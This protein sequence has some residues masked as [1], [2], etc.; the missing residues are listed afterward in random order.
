MDESKQLYTIVTFSSVQ[1]LCR[2]A[3]A[4]QWPPG[5]TAPHPGAAQRRDW[6]VP[7]ILSQ[8]VAR[9]QHGG[10]AGQ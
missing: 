10:D 7:W 8:A 5:P 9:P 4:S 6:A 1:S 2:S 3:A